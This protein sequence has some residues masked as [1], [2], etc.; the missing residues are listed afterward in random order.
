METPRYYR[1]LAM[2]EM[3]NRLQDRIEA[4]GEPSLYLEFYQEDDA[5]LEFTD[6]HQ[7]GGERIDVAAVLG[8]NG[9]QAIATLRA[10]SVDG[11]VALGLDRYGFDAGAGRVEVIVKEKGLQKIGELPDPRTDLEERLD[12]IMGEINSRTDLSEE[13]TARAETLRDEAKTFG[14]GFAPAAAVEILKVLA[15]QFG[16]PLP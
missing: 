16:V 4:T 8:T 2:L 6:E 14:R 7:P 10:L 5:R 3:L 1:R 11:Y 15:T 13:E 9:A 12:A